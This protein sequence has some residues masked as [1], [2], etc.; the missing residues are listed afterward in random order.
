[1]TKS[2]FSTLACLLVMATDLGAQSVALRG[3]L[4]YAAPDLPPIIDGTVV[5]QAGKI[6]A[7]GGAADIAIPTGAQVIDVNGKVVMAGFWN[8]HVHFP[9]NLFGGADT[10]DA[11]LLAVRLSDMLVRWGFTSVFDTGSPLANTLALR[12]RID[13]GKFQDPASLPPETSSTQLG[14]VIKSMW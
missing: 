11:A 1:M 8:S 10:V 6:R 14:R 13:A 9:A 7:V 2:L 12:R 5:L 3:G 4:I